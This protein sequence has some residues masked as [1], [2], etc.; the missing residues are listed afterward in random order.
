MM[1][2]L[3][4]V[5]AGALACAPAVTTIHGRSFDY[6]VGGNGNEVEPGHWA[7]TYQNAGINIDGV[8]E[9]GQE[10]WACTETG[11]WDNVWLSKT[12]LK[13]CTSKGTRVCK[14]KDGSTNTG[15]STA[16]CK[17]GPNGEMM[18]EGTGRQVSGTGRFEG[19]EATFSF[20]GY[21]VVGPPN[22][23]SYVEYTAKVTA[24]PKK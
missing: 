5:F 4:A 20:T 15:E 18:F 2:I 13:S 24:P 16:T 23:M 22:P 10:V 6:G 1:R 8:G 9:K 21:Q 12:E 3:L 11:T 14:A 17:L 19:A 7:G